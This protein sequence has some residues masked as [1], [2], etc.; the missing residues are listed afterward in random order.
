VFGEF[1]PVP[2]HGKVAFRPDWD[3]RLGDIWLQNLERL[4]LDYS[5]PSNGFARSVGA[6][7]EGPRRRERDLLGLGPG[8][9]MAPGE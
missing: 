6:E 3:R 8:Q 5:E 7:G 4:G 9:G 1:T 2:N